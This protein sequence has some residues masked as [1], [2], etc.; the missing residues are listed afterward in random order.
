MGNIYVSVKSVN[1]NFSSC[2]VE[3]EGLDLDQTDK[4]VAITGNA[5]AEVEYYCELDN[6]DNDATRIYEF[7]EIPSYVSVITFSLSERV[8]IIKIFEKGQETL[9]REFYFRRNYFKLVR[10]LKQFELINSDILK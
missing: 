10:S 5:E 1:L 4:E 8:Y 9:A 7:T 3:S 6:D 2:L